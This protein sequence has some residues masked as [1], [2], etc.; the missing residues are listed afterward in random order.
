MNRHDPARGEIE[1][2][3]DDI[4]D[5]ITAF[6]D[7]HPD[8]FLAWW[9]LDDGVTLAGGRGGPI[10]VGN[11]AVRA[12]LGRVS[13]AYGA[14]PHATSFASER[15][16]VEAGRDVAYVVQRER[17]AFAARPGTASTRTPPADQVYRVTMGLRREAEGW[18]VTHRHADAAITE[19]AT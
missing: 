14:A 11:D 6:V 3:L 1:Q 13:S 16:H 10:V 5:A 15:L 7:G 18:R 12:R 8:A 9:A 17:F 4:D 2:A 19:H